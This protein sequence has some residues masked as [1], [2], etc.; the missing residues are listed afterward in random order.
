LHRQQ[1][2][3]DKMLPMKA[4]FVGDPYH[5]AG[6]LLALMLLH[7]NKAAENARRF[8]LVAAPLRNYEG[9]A[10][11][12]TIDTDEECRKVLPAR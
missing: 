1:I 5:R 10:I 6:C 4:G 3:I 9:D 11:G 12:E 7:G 2:K 8:S